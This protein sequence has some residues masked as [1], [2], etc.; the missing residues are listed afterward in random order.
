MIS[1]WPQVAE[2]DLSVPHLLRGGKFIPLRSEDTG[3]TLLRDT[4]VWLGTSEVMT[5]SLPQATEMWHKI[6]NKS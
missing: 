5:Q 1:K 3:C 2:F 6:E 4:I